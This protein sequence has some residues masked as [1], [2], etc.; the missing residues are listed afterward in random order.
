MTLALVDRLRAL[1]REERLALYRSLPVGTLA[2]IRFDA[3]FWARPEQTLPPPEALAPVE[4][5]TGGRRAGKSA[6]ACWLFVREWREGRARAPRIVASNEGAIADTLIHGPSGL[7]SWLPWELR[8]RVGHD[9]DNAFHRSK[10]YGGVFAVPG[11][12]PITCLSAEKAGNAVGQGKDLTWADDPAAWVKVCGE[13]KAR[14][15]FYELR[16]S[17]SE[18]PR[19]CLIVSTTP[20]GVG[21]MRRAFTGDMRGVNKRNIGSVKDNTAIAKSFVEDVI[22]DLIG[23]GDDSD[24]TGAERIDAAGALWRWAWIDPYRVDA[25]PELERV[26][27]AVDPADTGKLDS[28]ETGIVVIGLGVDGRVY[29]LADYTGHWEADRWAAIAAWASREYGAIYHT[30]VAIVAEVNRCESTVRRCLA[31]EAPNVPVIGVDAAK[32]KQTRAEPLTL[33]Y[34][35]GQVSH[36]RAGPQIA[37]PGPMYIDVPIFNP[38]T[39]RRDVVPLEVKRDRRRWV[40]LEDEL[41]G[42]VPRGSRSPNGLDALVWGAWHL[43]PPD[44]AGPWEPAAGS[45]ALAGIYGAADPRRGAVDPRRIARL[46][47][48]RLGR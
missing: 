25:P 5:I 29:V 36:V 44:G 45:T 48:R 21:F 47:E 43:R 34:R 26:V 32:G 11:L 3:R 33:L 15:M 16:V 19:P 12:P 30:T 40:T 6:M 8:A 1:P 18:G 10:G 14:D 35:D 39:G 37:R 20:Q 46:Q 2:S 42:W 9:V 13:R 17:T 4:L 7:W 27:V 31:I 41:C 23:D 38:V 22:E 28:D 24:L